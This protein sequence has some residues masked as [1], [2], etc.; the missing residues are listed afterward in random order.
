[1]QYFS[2]LGYIK[3]QKTC[4]KRQFKCPAKLLIWQCLK[5]NHFN[6]MVWRHVMYRGRQHLVAWKSKVYNYVSHCDQSIESIKRF[7]CGTLLN[8]PRTWHVSTNCRHNLPLGHHNS[9]YLA[10]LVTC[11]R[12]LEVI[13][14]Y[15]LTNYDKVRFSPNLFHHE[16]Y[17]DLKQSP[18][19]IRFGASHVD[20]MK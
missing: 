10:Q 17:K 3:F 18:I 9:G 19:L 7:I 11:Q 14:L 2:N 12:S 5:G 20:L 8:A 1:M 13:Q 4:L 15:T 6:T 16:V